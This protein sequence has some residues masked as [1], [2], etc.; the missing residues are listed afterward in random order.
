MD[1]TK[2]TFAECCLDKRVLTRR[3]LLSKLERESI[4][5]GL[6]T[7]YLGRRIDPR[8]IEKF[9]LRKPA[10]YPGITILRKKILKTVSIYVKHTPKDDRLPYALPELLLARDAQKARL[11]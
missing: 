7:T 5:R 11:R 4:R 3:V 6:E 2:I 1:E 8:L 9:G 10:T